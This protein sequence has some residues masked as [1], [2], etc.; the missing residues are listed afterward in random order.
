[1][2]R[3]VPIDDSVENEHVVQI[4]RSIPTGKYGKN[5]VPPSRGD[6]FIPEKFP[7]EWFVTFVQQ[8]NVVK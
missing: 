5:G 1:M 7:L 3:G 8:E 2:M 4:A 6:P